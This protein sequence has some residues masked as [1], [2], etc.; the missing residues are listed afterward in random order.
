MTNLFY[1]PFPDFIEADGERYGILTDFREWLRFHDL[2][3]ETEIDGYTK[4]LLMAEWLEEPPEIVTEG[5]IRELT[6]FARA[7]ALFPARRGEESEEPPHPPWFDFRVDGCWIAGDFLRFYGIDLLGTEYLHWW[8]FCALLSALPDDSMTMK[9][10]A[11]RS[12]N[13]NDIKNPDERRRVARIQRRIAI[14][15]K[16]EDDMI[17]A[18]LWNM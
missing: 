12:A 15:Y 10:I 5:I 3:T 18:V 17:G 2:M 8:K 9:R 6:A 11:Y 1:E 4:A 13:L 14:P 16:M 7:D